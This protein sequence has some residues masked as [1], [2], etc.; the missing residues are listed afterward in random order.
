MDDFFKKKFCDRCKTSL[1]G[2]SFILSMFNMDVICWDCKRKEM[3]RPD[4]MTAL[5]AVREEERKGN[6][7]FE[8]IGLK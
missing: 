2:K 1:E 3:E 5:E 6:R 4:Y 8:G 7:N